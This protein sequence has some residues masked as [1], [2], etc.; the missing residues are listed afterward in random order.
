[1]EDVPNQQIYGCINF[2]EQQVLLLHLILDWLIPPDDHEALIL[3]KN[4]I[5][6][7]IEISVEDDAQPLVE[8]DELLV[9]ASMK[10]ARVSPFSLQKC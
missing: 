6:E 2:E 10:A 1:M 8:T 4:T 3:E 9:A 5:A 7:A